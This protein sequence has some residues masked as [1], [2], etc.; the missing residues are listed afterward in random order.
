MSNKYH[1]LEININN[2]NLNKLENNDNV[3][4]KRN[5]IFM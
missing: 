1:I 3:I 2:I 4:K 5:I